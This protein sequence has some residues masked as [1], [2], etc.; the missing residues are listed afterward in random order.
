MQIGFRRGRAVR[1]LGENPALD[2]R[3]RSFPLI[4]RSTAAGHENVARHLEHFVRVDP[5]ALIEGAQV[6]LFLDM[7]LG[8]FDVDPLGIV[9]RGRMIADPD[10]FHAGLQAERERRHRADIAEALDD[11]GT[12]CPDSSSAGPSRA[13]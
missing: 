5:V 11:G 3:P 9:E 13:R 6:A 7:L 8:R 4:T 2:F 1:A 10:H 12:I